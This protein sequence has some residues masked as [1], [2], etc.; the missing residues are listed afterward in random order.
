MAEPLEAL[1]LRAALGGRRVRDAAGSV[2]RAID[3][4]NLVV[5]V[6][7]DDARNSHAMWDLT[8]SFGGTADPTDIFDF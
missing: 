8:V 6:S 4:A 7:D 1:P 3:P 5:R 2:E